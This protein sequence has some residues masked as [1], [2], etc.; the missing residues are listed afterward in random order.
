[1][2]ALKNVDFPAEGFPTKN[3]YY[4]KINNKLFIMLVSALKKKI[5]RNH[6]MPK[7]GRVG[8]QVKK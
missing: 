6:P 4:L 1:M 7:E 3:I 8:T 5:I 2:A